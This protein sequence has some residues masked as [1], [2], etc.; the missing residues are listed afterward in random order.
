MRD[1]KHSLGR[2][3]VRVIRGPVA[4]DPPTVELQTWGFNNDRRRITRQLQR[5]ISKWGE[6]PWDTF[7][8]GRQAEFGLVK[9][10]LQRKHGVTLSSNNLLHTKHSCT[11]RNE[12][13]SIPN[14]INSHGKVITRPSPPGL[15]TPTKKDTSNR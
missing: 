1:V 12:V 6:R 13:G 7:I 8:E 4:V 3:V 5:V 15:N 10:F 2:V 9:G 14:I 11:M